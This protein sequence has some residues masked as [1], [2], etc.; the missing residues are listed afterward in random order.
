M[1]E[2]GSTGSQ[3]DTVKLKQESELVEEAIQEGI[4]KASDT[5]VQSHEDTVFQSTPMDRG[6]FHANKHRNR[7]QRSKSFD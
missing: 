5:S 6:R 3:N 1:D 2:E 7:P 4:K